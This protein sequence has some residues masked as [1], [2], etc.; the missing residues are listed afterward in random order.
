MVRKI[1]VINLF[2]YYSRN[3]TLRKSYFVDLGERVKPQLSQT[4]TRDARP[5]SN[6][7][8]VLP[9]CYASWK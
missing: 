9:S 1:N 5:N 3:C 4:F 8:P 7:R 2:Y 6:S